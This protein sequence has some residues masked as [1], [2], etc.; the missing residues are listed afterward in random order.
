MDAF[1]VW[2]ANTI[3]NAGGNADQYLQGLDGEC[4]LTYVPGRAIACQYVCEENFTGVN[5]DMTRVFLVAPT[6]NG[7]LN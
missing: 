1:Y 6:N 3:A 4:A 2:V 7:L 5:L